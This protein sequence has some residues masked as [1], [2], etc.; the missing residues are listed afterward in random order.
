[1]SELRLLLWLAT[2][3]REEL[4]AQLADCV[5]IGEC[6]CGCSSVQLATSAAPLPAQTIG[7]LSTRVRLD[8]VSLSSTGRDPAGH[9]VDLVLHVVG[10]RLHELEIFDPNAGEGTAVDPD[11]LVSLDRP[12]IG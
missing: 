5:V 10:G 1:M 7:R 4:A 8:Y 11:H 3:V 2:D 12:E 6:G 9:R